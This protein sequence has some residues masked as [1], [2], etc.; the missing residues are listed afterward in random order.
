MRRGGVVVRI[1]AAVHSLSDVG[2]KGARGVSL[3]LWP[4][5]LALTARHLPEM[6]SHSRRSS[7][8]PVGP[9]AILPRAGPLSM[10]SFP[11]GKDKSHRGEVA[12]LTKLLDP[13]PS[14]GEGRAGGELRTGRRP[15]SALRP[16]DSNSSGARGPACLSTTYSLPA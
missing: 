3:S 2:G 14:P 13:L 16:F 1:P 8:R 9:I 10:S 7:V 6:K 15:R 12:V 4:S 5:L 11:R